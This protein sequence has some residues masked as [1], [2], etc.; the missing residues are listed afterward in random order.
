MYSDLKLIPTALFVDK[1]YLL[2]TLLKDGPSI[3]FLMLLH[4]VFDNWSFSNY[5]RSNYMSIGKMYNLP[6]TCLCV[7]KLIEKNKSRAP[8]KGEYFVVI[9]RKCWLS[10]H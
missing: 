1:N 6:P 2:S 4:D 10:L 7:K 3:I 9:W 8:D 5:I